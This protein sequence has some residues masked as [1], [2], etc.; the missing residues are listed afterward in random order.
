M[1]YPGV[2]MDLVV[3]HRGFPLRSVPY[4]EGFLLVRRS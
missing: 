1:G 2:P 3:Q 4:D